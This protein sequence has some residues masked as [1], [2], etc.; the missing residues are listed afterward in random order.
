MVHSCVVHD[1]RMT[2]TQRRDVMSL[3]YAERV[4]ANATSDSFHASPSVTGVTV[5]SRVAPV[6]FAADDEHRRF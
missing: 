6:N 4:T 1:L 3:G 2:H 5:K